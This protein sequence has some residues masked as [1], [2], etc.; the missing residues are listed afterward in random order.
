[1]L[2]V[3]LRTFLYRGL[4]YG[5]FTIFCFYHGSHRLHSLKN[6]SDSS[7]TDS[8]TWISLFVVNSLLNRPVYT[9]CVISSWIV[10]LHVRV[11]LFFRNFVRVFYILRR[12][13]FSTRFIASCVLSYNNHKWCKWVLQNCI[14]FTFILLE[15]PSPWSSLASHRFLVPLFPVVLTQSYLWLLKAN[16]IIG[17]K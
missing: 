12:N 8:F 17:N 5:N 11:K 9:F 6:S 4:L 1:M 10:A 14:A 16:H 2:F 7:L 3:I 13:Y 15:D